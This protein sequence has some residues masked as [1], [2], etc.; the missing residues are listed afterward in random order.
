MLTFESDTSTHLTSSLKVSLSLS[1]E[2]KMETEPNIKKCH[3]KMSKYQ[4]NKMW[5]DASVC[6]VWRFLAS[7]EPLIQ[8]EDE[9]EVYSI[10]V[11]FFYM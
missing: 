6:Y 10:Q 9:C 1:S 3:N 4:Q 2:R 7:V 11:V 5:C 8:G